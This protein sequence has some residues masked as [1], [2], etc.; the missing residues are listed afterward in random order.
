MKTTFHRI[1][2]NHPLP[3]TYRKPVSHGELLPSICL[4]W[5]S[6]WYF[7]IEPSFCMWPLSSFISTHWTLSWFLISVLTI[8][9]DVCVL[10]TIPFQQRPAKRMQGSME[11]VVKPGDLMPLEIWVQL[12]WLQRS[13]FPLSGYQ[14]ACFQSTGFCRSLLLSVK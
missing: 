4:L 8:R 3:L 2:P 13:S 11:G 14:W 9:L 6:S 1:D 7:L 12:P 5:S 10:P